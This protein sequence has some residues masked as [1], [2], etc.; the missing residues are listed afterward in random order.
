MG[1]AQ[2]PDVAR[3]AEARHL[4]AVMLG[5]GIGDTEAVDR[6]RAGVDAGI[7]EERDRSQQQ[8]ERA[9]GHEAHA[10]TG[11]G[12]R[13]EARHRPASQLLVT[14][15][16]DRDVAQDRRDA[17][18][19]G[20]PL[21][22]AR[23]PEQIE[24]GGDAGED[25]GHRPERRSELHDAV[26]APSVCQRPEHEREDELRREEARPVETD[27]D[28]FDAGT[29]VIGQVVE[30]VEQHR[31]REAGAEAERER[32]EQDGEEGGCIS[33]DS[34][35]WAGRVASQPAGPATH[36]PGKSGHAPTG[37]VLPA[38]TIRGWSVPSSRSPSPVARAAPWWGRITWPQLPAFPS[39]NV[40]ARQSTRR[41]R[42]TPSSPWSRAAAA[43]WAATPSG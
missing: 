18:R 20:R 37:Q 41:S 9:R 23:R 12:C 39:S 4:L 15:S 24:V 8:P 10:Q 3:S 38:P 19:G 21:E 2:Q 28:R 29:T 42:P 7:D 33:G 31:A 36:Q 6:P 30:V 1:R 11:Q 25:H 35:G 27:H 32:P 14:G 16:R 13:L 40:A 34:S 17:R 26:V 22:Q 43:D 5:A